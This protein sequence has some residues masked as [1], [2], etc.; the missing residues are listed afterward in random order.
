MISGP[1]PSLKGSEGKNL[2]QEPGGRNGSRRHGRMLLIGFLS[3]A[4]SA[5]FVLQRRVGITYSDLGSY[6]PVVNQEKC[7]TVLPTG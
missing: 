4:C 3:I 6:M 5:C 2:G 7:P 1:S